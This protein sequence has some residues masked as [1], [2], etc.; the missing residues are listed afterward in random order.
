MVQ[1]FFIFILYYTYRAMP[2][3]TLQH[4]LMRL[5]VAGSTSKINSGA[6]EEVHFALDC[7]FIYLLGDLGTYL[8]DCL[9][10][11]YLHRS[12]HPHSSRV[13][14]LVVEFAQ[15]GRKSGLL[16]FLFYL[17]AC[18]RYLHKW[19]PEKK[20]LRNMAFTDLPIMTAQTNL[21]VLSLW[22][23]FFWSWYL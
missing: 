7:L 12:W 2:Y 13:L 1:L 20:A 10:L 19:R 9:A 8:P 17:C 6:R 23:G 3:C 16:F 4:N 18:H 11:P 5:R 21:S 22:F 15:V 14:V